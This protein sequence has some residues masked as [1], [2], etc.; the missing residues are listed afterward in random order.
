MSQQPQQQQQQYNV[1]IDVAQQLGQKQP[2]SNQQISELV[3]KTHQFIEEK[4]MDPNVSQQTAK[5]M[6]DFQGVLQATEQLNKNKNQDET[7]QK[8]ML[9][10]GEAGREVN[11]TGQ[12]VMNDPRLQQKGQQM[13]EQSKQLA[14]VVWAVIKTMVQSGEFRS[15]I[16]T[17]IGVFQEMFLGP[18]QQDQWQQQ[19]TLGTGYPG[20]TQYEQQPFQ[21]EGFQQQQWQGLSDQ[22]KRELAHQFL[23]V[24]RKL[25]QNE[26][27]R[28][29]FQ[30]LIQLFEDLSNEETYSTQAPQQLIQTVQQSE[31]ANTAFDESKKL[32]E[33][34]SERPLDPF[35]EK[36]RALFAWVRNNQQAREWL[37]RFTQFL[38]EVFQNPHCVDEYEFTRRSEELVNDANALAR[39]PQF[40][41]KYSHVWSELSFIVQSIREDPDLSHLQ[42]QTKIFLDN[43]TTTD[44]NGQRQFNT[45]LMKE[46]QTFIVP[47]MLSQLDNIPLP[48]VEGSNAEYDY[49]F[50]NMVLTGQEIIPD[51]VKIHTQS[52]TQLNV[53]NLSADQ[54]ESKIYLEVA[55]IQL[56]ISDIHFKFTRKTF[57]KI[58]DEGTANMRVEGN[59]GFSLKLELKVEM[60]DQGAPQFTLKQVDADIEKLKIEIV[61]AKHEFLLKLF[62]LIYQTK[63]KKMVEDNI[64]LKIKEVF[65]R[66]E[67]G[68]NNIFARFPPSRLKDVV[69]QK[70]TEALNSK[71]QSA[72]A[73][74]QKQPQAFQS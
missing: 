17:L 73:Q 2:P 54:A 26:S 29:G 44:A 33:R 18:V 66:I 67:E 23:N 50:D 72:Q 39:D 63:W 20:V 32:I 47:L 49:Y 53:R 70:A 13:K 51:M 8:I 62:A 65:G 36:N 58:S 21:T 12:Q 3:D 37:D 45:D 48:P 60:N 22:K 61:N 46:L 52:D 19:Q 43:F 31:H 38:R 11:Q 9:E 64:E 7:L 42:E 57:P 68:F 24:L 74:A 5:V 69:S 27:F 25:N 14:D 10:T 4:K 55:S 16:N 35:L 41:A 15:Q 6:T 40:K 1:A 59:Q 30:Q 56:K 71:N 34:F 28:C